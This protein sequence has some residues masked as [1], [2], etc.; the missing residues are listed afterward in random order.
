VR[1]TPGEYGDNPFLAL[2]AVFKPWLDKQGRSVR[3]AANGLREDARALDALTDA[4]LAGTPEWARLLLFIDQF[5]ELF[6]VVANQHREPFIALLEQAIRAPRMRTVATMRADFY[7]RCAAHPALAKLLRSGSYPLAAP[8]VGPLHHMIAGPAAR[9][10]LRFEEGLAERIL[11]N[12]GTE[13]GALPLLAFALAELYE[14]RERDG[15]LTHAAYERFDGVQG[16]VSK[17]AE[18]TV[19][20]LDNQVQTTLNRV[21]RELVEVKA[22]EDGWT[23]TRRRAPLTDVA[24]T[25]AAERLTSAFTKAR[26]LVQSRGEGARPVVEVAHE[27]LL[28][29]WPRLVQWIQDN[30]EA[31]QIRKQCR[32][33][34]REWQ[35]HA[36]AEEYLYRGSRLSQAEAWAQHYSD[37][38]GDEERAFLQAS[39]DLRQAEQEREERQRLQE[40]EAA[41]E[42]AAARRR[43]ILGLSIGLVLAFVTA[44]VAIV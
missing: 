5:E 33:A 44:R 2:A 24:T 4:A 39:F 21:F 29:S 42:L 8:G 41:Q 10:G 12:T 19:K 18:E 30:G 13:A 16:A 22:T 17:R 31:L 37:M 11:D 36:Q 32:E 26:L 25:A 15:R 28:R 38:V 27:A 34:A 14:L 23:A 1:F 35:Q 9:A 20:T 3:E 40:L 43:T 7:H 6:T